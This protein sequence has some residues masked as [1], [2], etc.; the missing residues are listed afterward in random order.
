[1]TYYDIFISYR[2]SIYDSAFCMQVYENMELMTWGSKHE[3][4][5]TFLDNK[6]LLTGKRFDDAFADA[7][8]NSKMAVPIISAEALKRMKDHNP[9]EVDNCLLEWI[10]MCIYTRV[11]R[12]RLIMPVLLGTITKMKPEGSGGYALLDDV[13]IGNF[14]DEKH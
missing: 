14:W 7:L 2:W 8:A 10:L 11:K 1:M 4:V 12:L 13:T 5:K 6:R 3:A 9:N